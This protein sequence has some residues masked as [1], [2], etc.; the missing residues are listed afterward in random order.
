VDR[1]LGPLDAALA[2]HEFLVSERFTIADISVVP[3]LTN[4]PMLQIDLTRFPNVSGWLSRV[5]GREAWK[6]LSG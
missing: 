5:T 3:T 4:A 1:C 6:R 2:G